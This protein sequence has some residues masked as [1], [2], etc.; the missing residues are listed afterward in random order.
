MR[1]S[2]WYVLTLHS[3]Q[4][5][6]SSLPNVPL[7]DR[8]CSVVHFLCLC[9][10]CNLLPPNLFSPCYICKCCSFS[11]AN[12]LMKTCLT[13]LPW[14]QWNMA[15]TWD[16]RLFFWFFFGLAS[17][18]HHS[19]RRNPL[20]WL[21]GC[22]QSRW[23]CVTQNAPPFLMRKWRWAIL[24]RAT[25]WVSLLPADSLKFDSRVRWARKMAGALVPGTTPYFCSWTSVAA[26]LQSL[27]LLVSSANLDFSKDYTAWSWTRSLVKS[28]TA[29]LY[30]L[31]TGTLTDRSSDHSFF[32]T[33]VTL[34]PYISQGLW[35]FLLCI[36]IIHLI[37]LFYAMAVPEFYIGGVARVGGEKY[38]GLTMNPYW[39]LTV[40]ILIVLLKSIKKQYF[41]KMLLFIL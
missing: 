35:H 38:K 1:T 37:V 21:W 41:L 3:I 30:Y 13:L 16:L 28:P 31:Q 7:R 29:S 25:S 11:K 15:N 4:M 32:Q 27:P 26:L 12:S 2:L 36:I 6:P 39:I 9:S 24:I 5:E 18:I 17:F 22:M 14:A 33:L 34:Y 20:I 10:Y 8:P 40:F 19:S 23:N